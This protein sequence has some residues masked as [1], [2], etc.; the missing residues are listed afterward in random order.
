MLEALCWT[1]EN[2]VINSKENGILDPGGQT[3][4]A[5][6]AQMLKISWRKCDTRIKSLSYNDTARELV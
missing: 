5:E 1:I 2:G 4:R 3:T 6:T